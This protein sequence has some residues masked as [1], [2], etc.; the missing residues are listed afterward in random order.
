MQRSLAVA[1]FVLLSVHLAYAQKLEFTNPEGMTTPVRYT[2]VVK[3]GNLLFISGQVGRNADGQI[4]GPGM[5]EQF[6][7]ALTNIVTA[8][9]SQGADITNVAKITTYVTS[10]S[11]YQSPEVAAIRTKHFGNHKPASTSLEVV[12][13]AN[14]AYRVEVE[15]IAVLPE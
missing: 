4:V 8:L 15:A 5:R 1:L 10:M 12:Q 14:P 7:Q 2:H 11:E 13:L 9:K 6:D 3:A